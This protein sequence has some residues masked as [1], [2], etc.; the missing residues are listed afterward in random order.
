MTG[1]TA[2]PTT[3]WTT[4]QHMVLGDTSHAYWNATTWT[5]GDAA[6]LSDKGKR[7]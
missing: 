7:G 2:T 4:G 6:L 5:A 3:A 1:I